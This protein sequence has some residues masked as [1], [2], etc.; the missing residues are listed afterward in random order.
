MRILKFNESN[1]GS[2]ITFIDYVKLCFIDLTDIHGI[3]PEEKTTDD[4]NGVGFAYDSE[5][6]E[7]DQLLWVNITKFDSFNYF[8]SIDHLINYNKKEFDNIEMIK[9][10][11]S[12][13]ETRYKIKYSVVD[14]VTYYNIIISDAI[15][16][17]NNKRV[18]Y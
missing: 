10:A 14:E 8:D 2:L 15:L 3:E 16:I 4:E 13:I 6:N 7:G 18:P 17:K 9:D 12:K 5:H 1:E 11:I